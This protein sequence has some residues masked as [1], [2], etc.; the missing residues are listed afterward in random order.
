MPNSQASSEKVFTVNRSATGINS[1]GVYSDGGATN[2][3]TLTASHSFSAGESVR[4]ISDSGQLPDGIEANTVYYVQTTGLAANNIKLAK[5]FQDSLSGSN[6]LTINEKGGILK[7]V[8]RVTDKNAGDIGHPIQYDTTNSQWYIKVSTASSDNT[9]YPIVV[10]FGSTGFGVSTPRTFFKRK[11]DNRNANDTLYRM[12]YVIPS[13]SGGTVARPPVE[14]FVLQESKHF[15]WF[16]QCLRFKH[17]L[18]VDLL[19]ISINKETSD[20]L[21]MQHGQIT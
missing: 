21:L 20:L 8:S 11:S 5:T 12:R 13:S 9:L 19:P 18:E 14:G 1:I 3:I 16:I 17:I 6:P 10:G 7:V 4:V 2:V 15:Y